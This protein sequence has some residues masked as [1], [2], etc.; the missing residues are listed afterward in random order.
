MARNVLLGQLDILNLKQQINPRYYDFLD[1]CRRPMLLKKITE[2]DNEK[3]LTVKLN[4][5]IPELKFKLPVY[6]H[7]LIKAFLP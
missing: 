4:P 6:L 1:E 3:F 5:S 7:D 2:A